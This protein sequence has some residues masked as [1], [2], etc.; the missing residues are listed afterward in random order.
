[1]ANTYELIASNTVGS[2]GAATVT[3]SGIPQTYTD[4]QLVCSLRNAGAGNQEF[5]KISFNSN[6]SGYTLKT[7]QGD[8]NATSSTDYSQPW[9]GYAVGADATASI[10]SNTQIYIPGYTLSNNKLISVDCV[11]ENNIVSNQ[12]IMSANLWS[13]TSAITSISLTMQNAANFVQYS[14]AYLYGISNN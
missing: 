10:F 12:M 8:G 2:G 11:P 7:L 1:M 4:L 13:N 6:T 3:F 14:T 9:F 5:V